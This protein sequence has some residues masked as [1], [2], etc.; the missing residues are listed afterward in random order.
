MTALASKS[1]EP[2]GVRAAAHFRPCFGFGRPRALGFPFVVQL[3]AL[4]PREFALDPAALQVDLG[5]NQR[6]PLLLG[7]PD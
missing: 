4:R 1:P 5:R 3:F 2:P 7:D 6:Q